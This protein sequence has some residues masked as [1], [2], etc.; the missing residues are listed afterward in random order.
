MINLFIQYT[1]Y[2]PKDYSWD[3]PGRREAFAQRVYSI[4]DEYAPG[5]SESIIGQDIL[6]PPDLERLLNLTGEP[7]VSTGKADRIVCFSHANPG[8]EA[9]GASSTRGT[10]GNFRFLYSFLGWCTDRQA[11]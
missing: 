4:I 11:F 7:L 8:P 2:K 6:T 10:S 5:F 1:P 3:E 9:C